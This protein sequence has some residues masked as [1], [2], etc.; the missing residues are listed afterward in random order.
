VLECSEDIAEVTIMGGSGFRFLVD[1]KKRTCTC[2]AWDV[3]GIP[4]KH[5]LAFITYQDAPIESY[6][7][8]YYSIERFRVA[9]SEA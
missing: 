9:Y 2:R 6:V 3:S 7:D 1:L 4:C 5:A 8:L